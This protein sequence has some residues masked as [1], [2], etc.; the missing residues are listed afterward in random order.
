LES[1]NIINYFTLNNSL[2]LLGSIFAL[3]IL[4]SVIISLPSRVYIYLALIALGI[5]LDYYHTNKCNIKK[6]INY[7]LNNKIEFIIKKILFIIPV[8]ILMFFGITLLICID[9]CFNTSIFPLLSKSPVMMLLDTSLVSGYLVFMEGMASS[10]GGNNPLPP[11]G[12]PQP[13]QGGP[14]QPPQNPH[15]SIREI[16]EQERKRRFVNSDSY[17]SERP[18]TVE[19]LNTSYIN[20][21]DG[22]QVYSMNDPRYTETFT[23]LDHNVVCRHFAYNPTYKSYIW[24]NQDGDFIYTGK[25][26]KPMI[27]ALSQ[28]KVR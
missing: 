23:P 21:P 24:V 5:L 22:P 1:N 26:N 2:K 17:E 19:K 6:S 20:R 4:V 15:V 28:P 11:Q 13:P 27:H 18:N 14:P 3:R 9:T 16:D 25:I 8:Y 12:G 10:S 7:I